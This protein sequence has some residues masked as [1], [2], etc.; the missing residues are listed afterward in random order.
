LIGIVFAQSVALPLAAFEHAAEPGKV[1]GAL[2]LFV[3]VGIVLLLVFLMGAFV[4][5]WTAR[6]RR[7]LAGRH[8]SAPTPADDVWAMHKLPDD[9]NGNED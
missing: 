1:A 9:A 7:A 4:L 3:L 2:S 8:L 6:R 5:V